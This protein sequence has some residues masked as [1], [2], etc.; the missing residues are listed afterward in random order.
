LFSLFYNVLLLNLFLIRPYTLSDS[1]YCFG[2]RGKG[3][4]KYRIHS[5]EFLSSQVGNPR[6]A[7]MRFFHHGVSLN[8]ACF[9]AYTP[10]VSTK[11]NSQARRKRKLWPYFHRWCAQLTGSH[12]LGYSK[13]VLRARPSEFQC[14]RPT[15]S[16]GIWLLYSPPPWFYSP[17]KNLGL[18]THRRF[19]LLFRHLV[20]LLWTS[21]KPVAK[22]CTCIGQDNT[23]RRENTFITWSGFEP[24]ILV[25]KW[26]RPTPLTSR[27]QW[28]AMKAQFKYFLFLFTV[29]TLGVKVVCGLYPVLFNVC[30]VV[31][32]LTLLL[33]ILE[34]PR[35]NLGPESG[36]FGWGF[37]WSFSVPPDKFRYSTSS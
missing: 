34:V 14:L 32:W 37:S 23:E 13:P 1:R 30:F 26:L 5:P 3:W 19:L 28:L 8:V 15:S 24:T 27:P 9:A 10:P 36:Y 31:V 16:P 18:L 33:R 7:H 22:A 35:S 21:D 17:W 12:R 11:S 20:E 6:R 2:L 25:S 29:P 4:S